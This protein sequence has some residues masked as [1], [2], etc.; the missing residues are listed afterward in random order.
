MW[1]AKLFGGIPCLIY[2]LVPILFINFGSYL[3]GFLGAEMVAT[4]TGVFGA[5][6]SLTWIS[7]ICYLL[8]WAVSICWAFP[9]KHKIRKLLK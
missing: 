2:W 8:I 1:Y 7:G 4:I 9:I 6:S 5:I 3:E